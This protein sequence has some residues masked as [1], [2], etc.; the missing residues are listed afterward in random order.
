MVPSAV[1]IGRFSALGCHSVKAISRALRMP[2][3]RLRGVGFLC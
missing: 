2:R 1:F 3:S